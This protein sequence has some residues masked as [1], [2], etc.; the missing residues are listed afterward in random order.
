MERPRGRPPPPFPSHPG[1]CG[2]LVGLYHDNGSSLSSQYV[3]DS[4]I[5]YEGMPT[6]FGVIGTSLILISFESFL[7]V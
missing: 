2:A 5:F 4:R 7:V 6:L 3:G 1:I